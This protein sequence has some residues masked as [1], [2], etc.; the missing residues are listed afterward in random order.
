MTD[1][2]YK[3]HFKIERSFMEMETK[4]ILFIK[5]KEMAEATPEDFEY[6]RNDYALFC[7]IMGNIAKTI[8]DN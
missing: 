1:E 3:N 8:L 2:E 5:L 7:S 4:K 6:S